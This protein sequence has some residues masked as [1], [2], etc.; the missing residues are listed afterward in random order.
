MA[1]QLRME[2]HAELEHHG[3]KPIQVLDPVNQRLYFL[4]SS[5]VFEKFKDLFND[6]NFDLS[7]TYRSQSSVAGAAGWDDPEMDV[8]DAHRPASNQ[9]GSYPPR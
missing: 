8:Y 6:E 5:D 3:V 9:G 2:Q 1:T 7:E 4:V